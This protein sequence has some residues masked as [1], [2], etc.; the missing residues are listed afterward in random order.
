M[1]DKCGHHICLLRWH[2]V[3][4]DVGKRHS[5]PYESATIKINAMT[6]TVAITRSR[7][8]SSNLYLYKSLEDW[9]CWFHAFIFLDSP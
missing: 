9:L 6:E 3:L 7:M 5:S 1:L 8:L 4:V 2:I